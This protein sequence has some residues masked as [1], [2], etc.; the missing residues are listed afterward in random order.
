MLSRKTETK[1][2]TLPETGETWQQNVMHKPW[3][4]P[5]LEKNKNSSYKE[6]WGN[7]LDFGNVGCILAKKV[8]TDRIVRVM[9]F[10]CLG[11]KCH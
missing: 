2:D 3:L 10:K 1:Q 7:N 11:A 8:N 6:N 9:V 4:D 5:S